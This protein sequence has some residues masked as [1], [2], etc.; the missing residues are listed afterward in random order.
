M[1]KAVIFAATNPRGSLMSDILRRAGYEPEAVAA[2]NGETGRNPSDRSAPAG[3]YDPETDIRISRADLLAVAGNAARHEALAAAVARG[4]SLRRAYGIRRPLNTIVFANRP[5]AAAELQ[6]EV[7]RFLDP[8]AGEY[9]LRHAGF[10]DG[11][12]GR[13][14][15]EPV[16]PDAGPAPELAADRSA[17]MAPFPDIPGMELA[18]DAAGYAARRSY[19]LLTGEAV[20]AYTGFLRGHATVSDCM[21]DALV[22]RTAVRAMRESASALTGGPLPDELREYAEATVRR[23]ADPRRGR[24]VETVCR[25][26][27]RKL[28]PDERLAAPAARAWRAGLPYEGLAL[29]I[30]AAL[31]YDNPSDPES[32]RMLGMT[33]AAPIR[34]AASE[35]TGIDAGSGLMDAVA[36][37]YRS[38]PYLYGRVPE[39]V[40]GPE[41]V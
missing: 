24:P 23:L 25:N 14:L 37:A 35:I 6:K 41:T 38:A 31:R 36:S 28:S 33:A 7:G 15:W 9:A 11:F 1:K 32:A 5:G 27:L 26:P 22:R 39:T 34:T 4:I 20:A 40:A 3:P 21:K 10:A 16:S 17:L 29:G 8:A 12:G 13:E 18:A 19:I 2:G 30:A